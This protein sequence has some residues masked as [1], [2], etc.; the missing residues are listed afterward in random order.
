MTDFEPVDILLAEDNPTDAELALR[1]LSRRKLANKVVWVRDGREALDYLFCEGT[2]AGRVNGN[3]KL[4]LLDLKMP[5]VDGLEVL[6]RVKSDVR[7]R[8]TP[9]VIMTSS[10]EERDLVESYRLGAN[11]FIVK[12][13]DFEQ[14]VDVVSK[15]GFY[16]AVMNK[17]PG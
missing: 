8:P 2:Y 7:T 15:A 9:V 14:F 6:E 3:P 1:A 4:I 13:V 11:S 16:W 17:V 12:P 5:K 10:E